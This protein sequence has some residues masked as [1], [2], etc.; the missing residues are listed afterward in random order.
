MGEWKKTSCYNCGVCCGLEV[1]IE[2]NQV[3]GVRPDPAS[4]RSLGGYCCRKGRSLQYF[5]EN[6]NRL[7]HPLKRVGDEFVEISWDQALSEIGAKIKELRSHYG[8]KAFGVYGVGLA[9]DQVEMYPWRLRRWSGGG[10]GGD[11]PSP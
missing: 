8:P 7:N 11:V 10:P 5:Q 4:M 6:K 1:K 9:V 2:N 3:V